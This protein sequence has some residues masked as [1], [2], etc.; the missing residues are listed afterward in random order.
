MVEHQALL[1]FAKLSEVMDISLMIMKNV[2][3]VMLRAM[4][5]EVVIEKLKK[6]LSV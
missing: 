1:M 6:G 5:D 4:M 2:M 3:M